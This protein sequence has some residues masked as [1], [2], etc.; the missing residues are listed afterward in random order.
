[1]KSIYFASVTLALAACG[2]Q[3]GP[4]DDVETID[5]A[6]DTE[7]VE[8]SP[9][10][11]APVQPL[12]LAASEPLAWLIETLSCEGEIMISG[13]LMLFDPDFGERL[14]EETRGGSEAFC[15][16]AD[17]EA[18]TAPWVRTVDWDTSAVSDP[19]GIISL[20]GSHYEYAGGA[21]GNTGTGT[22]IW[23]READAEVLGREMFTSDAAMIEALLAPIRAEIQAE[24]SV[25]YGYDL[26]ASEIA[27][28]LSGDMIWFTRVSL[29]PSTEDGQFGGLKVHFDPYDIGVYAEGGYEA[30][31]PQSVF[32]DAL[33]S[34]WT[35]RFGGEMIDPSAI[36]SDP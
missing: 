28:L 15:A 18:G 10:P 24:K 9:E 5:E 32:R 19:H 6:P 22:I 30:A 27:D 12:T 16:L 20:V 29:L 4:T 8:T 36:I 23:D 14:F 34:E 26:P 33:T 1:M 17:A 35:A 25:R 11:I 31:V 21:H 3:T 13:D 2:G 7:I